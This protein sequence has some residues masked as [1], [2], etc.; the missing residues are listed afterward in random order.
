MNK[1]LWKIFAR[2]VEK[3]ENERLNPVEYVVVIV[4]VI[5]III[6]FAFSI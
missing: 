5:L 3:K 1:K 4:A 2:E 6:I